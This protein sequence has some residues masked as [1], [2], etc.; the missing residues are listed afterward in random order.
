MA[1]FSERIGKVSPRSAIQI[2]AM[3]V[4]LRNALWNAVDVVLFDGLSGW[5][6]AHWQWHLCQTIWIEFFRLPVDEID[7]W[8]PKIKERIRHW[9]F[10][11]QW[12]EVYDFVEFLAAQTPTSWADRFMFA[13]TAALEREMSGYRF[14]AGELAPMTNEQE[15]VAIESALANTSQLAAVQSHLQSALSKLSHRTNPDFRNS[16]KESISAVEAL[17][18]VI[19]GDDRATLGQALKRL[20]DRGL[21]F[22]PALEKAWGSLY[23]Y[24]NDEDGIRHAM[25]EESSLT[26]ADAKY[27]LVSCSAFITYLIELARDAGLPLK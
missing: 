20:T 19:A 8:W 27:F 2:E 5:I 25:L 3:D 16:I 24:T 21:K 14:V 18:R 15:I 17:C 11:A 1:R 13:T 4:P 22:H 6:N 12:Y 26:L 7:G 23:G 9:F 10:T